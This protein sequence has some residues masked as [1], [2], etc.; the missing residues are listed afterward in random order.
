MSKQHFFFGDLKGFIVIK[1]SKEYSI[2][3]GNT[4]CSDVFGVRVI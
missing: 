1:C 2:E 4:L 3:K